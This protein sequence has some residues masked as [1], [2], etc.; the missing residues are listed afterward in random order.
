MGRAGDGRRKGAPVTVGLEIGHIAGATGSAAV[1]AA[2]LEAR[3]AGG[4]WQPV[5]LTVTGT[6]NSGP[7]E[8]P[9]D[10]FTAGRAFLTTYGAAIPVADAG[11]WV[12][13]RVTATDAAGGTLSQEIMKAFQVA[14]A[15][16]AGKPGKPG[17]G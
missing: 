11:G 10:G 9:G 3:T 4:D 8:V 15:K 14:P 12:D 6:D 7:G 2:T 13:L 17:R 1:S 16:G 5:P